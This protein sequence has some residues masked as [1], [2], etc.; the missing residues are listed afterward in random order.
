MSHMEIALYIAVGAYAVFV[1][2]YFIVKIIKH[3]RGK[4]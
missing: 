4:K 3:R 1:A 2:V